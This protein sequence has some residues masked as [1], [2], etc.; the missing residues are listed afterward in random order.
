MPFSADANAKQTVSSWLLIL[1]SV[2]SA[3]VHKPCCHG[4]QMLQSQWWL[5]G[6]LTSNSVTQMSRIHQ[7]LNKVLS[8][9]VLPY[10]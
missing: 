2:F 9:R 7:S 1:A 8:P 3:L 10:F 6:D 5:Y 4:G